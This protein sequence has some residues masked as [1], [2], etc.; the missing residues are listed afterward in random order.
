MK[1]LL[2]IITL[3]FSVAI[4]NVQSQKYLRIKEDLIS[5]GKEE[6]KYYEGSVIPAD[7]AN[8]FIQINGE[9]SNSNKNNRGKVKKGV[10]FP[11]VKDSTDLKNVVFK[12][13]AGADR[14]DVGVNISKFIAL[15]DGVYME[16]D[17]VKVI[18]NDSIQ[19][20][21]PVKEELMKSVYDSMNNTLQLSTVIYPVI[22]RGN[23]YKNDPIYNF[24]E[25]DSIEFIIS[26]EDAY[27][28]NIVLYAD[29]FQTKS[30]GS[31][32][33]NEDDCFIVFLKDYWVSI[34]IILVL[35]ISLLVIV[36]KYREKNQQDDEYN[37]N[38]EKEKKEI[39]IDQGELKNMVSENN[40]FKKLDFS[41]I[42]ISLGELTKLLPQTELNLKK[43]ILESI[44]KM[45]NDNKFIQEQ[46][47]QIKKLVVD[48]NDKTEINSLTEE[49]LSK[50]EEFIDL[51]RKT[52]DLNKQIESLTNKN[53]ELKKTVESLSQTLDKTKNITGA[54]HIEVND[55]FL[56]FAKNLQKAT[57]E[58]ETKVWA[59]YR[60]LDE[61]DKSKLQYFISVFL[62]SRPSA[63]ICKWN[64]IISNLDL[65]GYIKD[66]EFNAY[67]KKGANPG[68][69]IFKRFLEEFVR[70]YVSGIV[71]LLEQ[72][73]T[74][75]KIGVKK[76]C[77]KDMDNLIT[78]IC[79]YC[80]SQNIS[81]GYRKL[82]AK[83]SEADFSNLEIEPQLP[84]ELEN[85][86]QN[87]AEEKDTLLAVQHYAVNCDKCDTSEKTSCVILI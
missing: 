51:T 62:A 36:W 9:P 7:S 76:E 56:V 85:L 59:F 30:E 35:F 80:Q 10:F 21:D 39:T 65:N 72:I 54:L 87:D 58:A 64:G 29:D 47:T 18:P 74:A 15:K 67:L 6:K 31:K 48:K 40:S 66:I 57:V 19:S 42:Q 3:F 61:L 86:L 77:G 1:R 17:K 52:N 4:Y 55:Q 28:P 50:K 84:I 16:Y 69:F 38:K 60:D 11:I 27:I 45:N 13:S 37:D 20:P 34:I 83:V 33:T 70:P 23:L 79:S 82:Y 32:A 68:L 75:S 41:D 53:N 12:D 46:L 73:R 22:I 5:K 8:L 25:K 14:S 2:F 44:S 71:L 81:L 26:T 49:L 24:L 63:V 78:A 43:L